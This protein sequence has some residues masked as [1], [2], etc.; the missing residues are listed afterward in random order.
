MRSLQRQIRKNS[1][2]KNY[3]FSEQKGYDANAQFPTM[4]PGL[5][6]GRS[7]LD[8]KPTVNF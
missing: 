6:F 7:G 2:Y 4:S 3:T 8:P 5:E 1:W